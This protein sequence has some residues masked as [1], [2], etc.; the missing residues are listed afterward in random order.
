MSALYSYTI[1]HAMSFSNMDNWTL[2]FELKRNNKRE[3]KMWK[4]KMSDLNVLLLRCFG[5]LVDV[6][7]GFCWFF[8]FHYV[9]H[10]ATVTSVLP[11]FIFQCSAQYT[12]SRLLCQHE[13]T[14]CIQSTHS[15]RFSYTITTADLIEVKEASF[16]LFSPS[17]FI[18]TSSFFF[19]NW[20][21]T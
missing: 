21:R 20:L 11:H 6:L 10:V 13:H 5:V 2:A 9:M 7:S 3:N 8:L 16:N 18:S 4:H 1:R 19:T 15:Y 14:T 17:L 12:T